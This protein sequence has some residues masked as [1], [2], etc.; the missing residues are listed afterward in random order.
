MSSSTRTSPPATSEVGALAEPGTRH[1]VGRAVLRGVTTTLLAVLGVIVGG[2]AALLLALSVP[3]SQVV[4]QVRLAIAAQ[5]WG[6]NYPNDG[7]GGKLD[8]YTECLGWTLGLEKPGLHRGRLERAALSP[9]LGSC[10]NAA[11]A[12]RQLVAHHGARV[13]SDDYYR[14]WHGYAALTRPL[15]GAFGVA[16]ARLA[17]GAL[18]VASLALLYAAVRGA[19][20]RWAG[21]GLLAPLVLTS[22][23][24]VLEMAVTQAVAMVGVFAAAALVVWL[25]RRRGL[26]AVAWSSALA[27]SLFAYLDLL[28]TPA[29]AWALTAV[30]AGLGVWARLRTLRATALALVISA[31]AWAFGFA[32]TWAAK[33]GLAAAY[34]GPEKVRESITSI[35]Q[36]RL[37]GSDGVL[38]V[39]TFGAAVRANWVYWTAHLHTAVPTLVAAGVALL[40]L[41]VLAWR[42]GRG[43]ALALVGLLSTPALLVPAWYETL[44]NHSQIHAWF[45]YRSLPAGV[46]VV[47]AAAAVA[48]FG[49]SSAQVSAPEVPA[50]QEAAPGG[51]REGDA[52]VPSPSA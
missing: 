17:V 6:P 9:Y 18:L 25:T 16:G 29:L 33:W 7:L 32:A 1:T 28:T 21:I 22:N 37:N 45:T 31:A 3:N 15:L 5:D 48:A 44:S 50:R 11:H 49:P 10:P 13:Q 8:R 38:V 36:Y 39:H 19:A 43:R 14:Y 23:L 2:L 41:L 47:L 35:S 20:G 4:D 26:P 42:R 30:A 46:G 40:T 12:V 34:V 52:A 27:G 24:I 51:P